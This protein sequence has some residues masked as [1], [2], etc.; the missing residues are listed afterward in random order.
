[1]MDGV[2]ADVVEEVEPILGAGGSGGFFGA[3]DLRAVEAVVAV[4]A[5]R[6]EEAVECTDA[7][8]L[9]IPLVGVPPR[10]DDMLEASSS[11]ARKRAAARVMGREGALAVGTL[12]K[13]S[14]TGTSISTGMLVMD[15]CY[16]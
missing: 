8:D 12:L 16:V 14:S 6:T 9:A 7:F 4:A 15:A 2:F 5:E 1:M 11:V 13:R 3:R 10:K